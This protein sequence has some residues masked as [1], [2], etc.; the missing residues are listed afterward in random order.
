MKNVL[1]NGFFGDF[2]VLFMGECALFR[3][4]LWLLG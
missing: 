4:E 2:D 3:Q 1:E